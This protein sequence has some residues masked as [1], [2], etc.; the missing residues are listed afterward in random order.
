MLMMRCT[1]IS[2]FLPLKASQR[3]SLLVLTRVEIKI[4]E[5]YSGLA[6]LTPARRDSSTSST[7]PSSEDRAHKTC[8]GFVD[9]KHGTIRISIEIPVDSAQRHASR[10]TKKK[11]SSA[12]LAMPNELLEIDIQQDLSRLHSSA[13]DTGSVVWQARWDRILQSTCTRS[14]VV[15]SVELARHLLCHHRHA[16][17]GRLLEPHLL[18]TARILELGAGTG[19]LSILLSSRVGSWHATDIEALLPL[20]R[21]NHARNQEQLGIAKVRIAELDWAW[22]LKQFESLYSIMPE[23]PSMS[24]DGPISNDFDLVIAVDCLYNESLVQAFVDTLQK[25]RSLFVIVVSELRSPE[26]LRLFLARWLAVQEDGKP[27]WQIW[28]ACGAGEQDADGPPLL[29][30]K[31]VVWVAWKQRPQSSLVLQPVFV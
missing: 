17:A 9:A 4:F 30:R 12:V 15:R 10:R 1:P 13:G 27:A 2:P 16:R 11:S 25:I 21:K 18:R 20:I 14:R 6:A 31:Y 5:L 3:R 8:L 22:S 7:A 26:V 19:A 23:G 29:G 24:H 28:R